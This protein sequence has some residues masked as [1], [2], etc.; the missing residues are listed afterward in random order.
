VRKFKKHNSISNEEINA[1]NKVIKSGNLS[2]FYAQ[3][4]SKFY[5]GKNVLKFE[6]NIKNFFGVKYAISVNSWTSGLITSIGSIDVKPGDE[7][8]L[9]P[10]TMSACAISI[11]HWNAIPVFADVDPKTF[12]LSPKSVLKKITKKTKAIMLVDITGHPSDIDAFKKI[13][14]KYKLKLIIDAAQSI[15]AKYLKKNKYAGTVGDVGGFSFN[16]HKHINTGEGGVIVT[17]NKNIANKAFLIR[18]HG[19]NMAGKIRT[20]NL[21]N[22]IGY[23]FRLGEIEA[24]I[25]IEQLK[26][27]PKIL[28]KIQS[29]ASYLNKELKKLEGLEVPEVDK[30]SIT[31]S[32]YTYGLKLNR[33]KIKVSRKKIVNMLRNLGVPCGEGYLNIHLLPVFKKKIAYGKKNYPWTLNKNRSYNY[34]RGDMPIAEDLHFK[35]Y[36]GIGLTHYDFSSNDIIYIIK[37]FREVWTKLGL[38]IFNDN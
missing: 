37:V 21:Y 4:L 24:A 27:L 8:I 1:A 7:I 17:N 5:G 6:E 13:A 31:H 11:L 20:N 3:N 2:G 19:E 35:S 12:C 25:G 33:K 29:N 36:I 18:N 16:T 9:P 14:K 22:L 23:N 26:K 15:G 32:Y 34:K 28:G 10:F 38:K 30:K